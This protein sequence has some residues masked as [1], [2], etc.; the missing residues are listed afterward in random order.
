[1]SIPIEGNVVYCWWSAVPGSD[2]WVGN[3]LWSC[4]PLL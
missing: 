2:M 4:C 3:R 1:L